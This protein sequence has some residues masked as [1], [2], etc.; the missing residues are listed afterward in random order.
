MTTYTAPSHFELL[1]RI[2]AAKASAR[3]VLD[4][5]AASVDTAEARLDAEAAARTALG[6]IASFLDTLRADLDQ[7]ESEAV[8]AF[9]M[10]QGAFDAECRNAAGYSLRLDVEEV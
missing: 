9:H 10:I 2:A 8:Q 6:R 4:L 7:A 5:A 1:A 3:Q